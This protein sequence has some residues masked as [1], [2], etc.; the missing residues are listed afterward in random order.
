MTFP[1]VLHFVLALCGSPA[2]ATDGTN[3][4]NMTTIAITV[5]K[6]LFILVSLLFRSSAQKF[7]VSSISQT[8]SLNFPLV[9]SESSRRN[10][11]SVRLCLTSSDKNKY[12][13][14]F[15]WKEPLKYCQ[16]YQFREVKSIEFGGIPPNYQRSNPVRMPLTMGHQPILWPPRC[17]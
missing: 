1:L 7:S 5:L 16:S 3:K 2:N 11:T 10:G 17:S 9:G 15:L 12:R 14:S 8:V 13:G 4:A 6:L